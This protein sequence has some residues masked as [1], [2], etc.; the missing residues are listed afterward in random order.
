[1]RSRTS[2]GRSGGLRKRR[3][4][5]AL[6]LSIA[7]LSFLAAVR[8]QPKLG[9]SV[10]ASALASLAPPPPL[11]YAELGESVRAEL[12]EHALILTIEKNDTLD[13]L[14]VAGGLSRGESGALPNALSGSID[15]R[16]LRPGQLIRFHYDQ[17]GTVDA[18]QMKVTG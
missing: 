5:L 6:A 12:P 10:G 16:R 18:V 8:S 11:R 7:V 4:L 15:V 2:G 17:T 14:L 9:G 13:R 1:M 3:V